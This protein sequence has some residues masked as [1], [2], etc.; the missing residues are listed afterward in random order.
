[1]EILRAKKFVGQLD[2]T[3]VSLVFFFFFFGGGGG[4]GGC[5]DNS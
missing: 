4:G 5:L 2:E 1:M 3:K